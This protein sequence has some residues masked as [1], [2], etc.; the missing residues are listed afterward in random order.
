[1][2]VEQLENV[3]LAVAS[4]GVKCVLL[5]VQLVIEA[6]CLTDRDERRLESSLDGGRT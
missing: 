1:M 5:A 4:V 6:V 2:I 3:V